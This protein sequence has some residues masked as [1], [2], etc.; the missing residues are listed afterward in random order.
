MAKKVDYTKLDYLNVLNAMET[1]TDLP[2]VDTDA[3]VGPESD[4]VKPKVKRP[5]V[6]RHSIDM[7]VENS[8]YLARLR[9]FTGQSI[10]ELV[11]DL[12]TEE[13]KRNQADLNAAWEA[14]NAVRERLKKRDKDNE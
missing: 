5:A 4:G 13:R 9:E 7:D 2:L 11:N 8:E 6:V 12:I 3:Q 14:S 1:R 10:R